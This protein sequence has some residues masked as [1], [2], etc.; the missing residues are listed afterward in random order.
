MTLPDRLRAHAFIHD[1]LS[2][3][4]DTEQQRAFAAD[5]R[6]AADA[7]EAAG[8]RPIATAPQDTE[9][10]VW[11]GPAAGVKSAT[12]TDKDDDGILFWCVTDGKFA[13]HPVRR[14][15]APYP[16]HWMPLPTPPE[17]AT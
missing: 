12:Y 9:V 16:T 3:G 14:Y 15:C 7:L 11:F 5:M 17:A 2:V 8:W 6:A 1:G 13:P 10:L 4:M